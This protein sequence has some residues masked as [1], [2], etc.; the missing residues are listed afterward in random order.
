MSKAAHEAFTAAKQIRALLVDMTAAL[1]VLGKDES[2]PS[3]Q[4]HLVMKQ[5]C[6]LFST[7]YKVV[8]EYAKDFLDDKVE[9]CDLTAVD[10]FTLRDEESNDT[11]YVA[12]MMYESR[13]TKKV[14]IMNKDPISWG[15]L[16][17]LLA[18]NNMADAVQQRLTV[19]KFDGVDLNKFHGLLN[20]SNG[21]QWS[22]TKPAQA[23]KR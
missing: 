1:D 2:M 19:S 10:G 22:I 14:E 12:G 4:R 16:L 20:I 5:V 11:L 23:K 13:Q 21:S 15:Q 17:K 7:E 8:E 3:Q 9:P 18:D 6:A